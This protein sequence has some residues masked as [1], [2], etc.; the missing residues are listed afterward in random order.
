LQVLM[1]FSSVASH[2]HLRILAGI[3]EKDKHY[4]PNN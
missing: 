2:V 3:N 1:A 4:Q